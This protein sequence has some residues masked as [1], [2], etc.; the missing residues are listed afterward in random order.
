MYDRPL[1]PTV[2]AMLRRMDDP[3]PE[4]VERDVLRLTVPIAAPE[5]AQDTYLRFFGPPALTPVATHDGRKYVPTAEAVAAE[6][7]ARSE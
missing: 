4:G 2:A 7:A 3:L 6:V 5:A 1:G